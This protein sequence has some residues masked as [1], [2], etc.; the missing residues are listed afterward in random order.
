[1]MY[2][3]HLIAFCGSYIGFVI[4]IDIYDRKT[5]KDKP[6]ITHDMKK[7]SNHKKCYMLCFSKTHKM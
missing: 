2:M 1:M 4:N 6:W 7:A 3:K 5:N